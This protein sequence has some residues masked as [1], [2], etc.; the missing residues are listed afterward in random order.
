MA[1]E[2]YKPKDGL[3]HSAFVGLDNFKQLF[4]DAT[5]LRVINTLAMGVINLVAT[6]SWLLCLPYF[7]MRFDPEEGKRWCRRFTCRTFFPDRGNGILH[8]ALSGTGIINEILVNLNILDQPLNFFGIRN[9][10]AHR[11]IRK[12]VE[13]NGW[14]AIIYLS[15]ITA[16]DPSL[17]EAASMDGER[18]GKD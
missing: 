2:D 15:A 10:S 18:L 13:G 6:L 16:I 4:S 7:E 3:L 12:C 14:N 17:Y 9:T 8:D 5:F 11:G 1:F